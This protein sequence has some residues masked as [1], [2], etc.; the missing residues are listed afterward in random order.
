[1]NGSNHSLITCARILLLNIR[2]SKNI[3]S[4]LGWNLERALY[5]DNSLIWSAK[6]PIHG[7]FCEPSFVYSHTSIFKGAWEENNAFSSS[8]SFEVFHKRRA[9]WYYIG[10]YN[11]STVHAHREFFISLDKPVHAHILSQTIIRPELVAPEYFSQESVWRAFY[12]LSARSL[13]E[14]HSTQNC[15]QRYE[16]LG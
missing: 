3:K 2:L 1:M 9:A 13:W 14:C 5:F 6:R 8:G 10:N 7:I 15:T 16:N 4:M 11:L 12:V